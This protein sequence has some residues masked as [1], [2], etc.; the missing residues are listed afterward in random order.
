MA[1]G[2]TLIYPPLDRME[3]FE[4]SSMLR[5]KSIWNTSLLRATDCAVQRGHRK[6]A[7]YGKESSQD[8]SLR[9]RAG[10]GIWE[11]SHRHT[12]SPT[13]PGP[14]TSPTLQLASH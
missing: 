12:N 8:Q 13:E 14:G 2:G 7:R 6:W 5:L 3:L 10:G 1:P 9:F 11:N 4:S